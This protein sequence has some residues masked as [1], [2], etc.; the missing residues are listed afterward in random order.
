MICCGTWQ[1]ISLS[2]FLL[3]V[4]CPTLQVPFPRRRISSPAQ[5][6]LP[7]PSTSFHTSVLQEQVERCLRA[8]FHAIDHSLRREISWDEF[9]TYLVDASQNVCPCAPLHTPCAPPNSHMA[10]SGCVVALSQWPQ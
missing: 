9:L 10:C 4:P 1:L 7:P 2:S 3:W 6:R 8:L 5:A